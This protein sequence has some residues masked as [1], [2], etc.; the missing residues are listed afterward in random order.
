MAYI[1]FNGGIV[2]PLNNGNRHSLGSPQ[3]TS[4]LESPLSYTM[5]MSNKRPTEY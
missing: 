5:S 1:P 2:N 3:M 4:A